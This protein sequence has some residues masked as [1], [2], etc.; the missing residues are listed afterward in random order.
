M[1]PEYQVSVMYSG[2]FLCVYQEAPTTNYLQNCPIDLQLAIKWYCSIKLLHNQTW[3]G[4]DTPGIKAVSEKAIPSGDSR[5]SVYDR[6]LTRMPAVRKRK[7]AS[8]QVAPV[9]V[10]KLQQSNGQDFTVRWA[11]CSTPSTAF[12]VI[13][14]WMVLP[15]W[16]H[17]IKTY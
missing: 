4:T 15:N 17:K 2:W 5:T 11:F 1:L 12:L 9:S 14:K 3:Y 16:N 6:K 13:Y 8:V 10:G 7:Y